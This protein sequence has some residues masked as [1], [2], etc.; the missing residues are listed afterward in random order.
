MSKK[1]LFSPCVPGCNGHMQFFMASCAALALW[2]SSQDYSLGRVVDP[3]WLAVAFGGLPLLFAA[4]THIAKHGEL[5]TKALSSLVV[6]ALCVLQTPFI[7]GQVA[8]IMLFGSAL[9]ICIACFAGR[10]LFN[11]FARQ[12]KAAKQMVHGSIWQSEATNLLP[13][14]IVQIEPQDI[15]PVDGLVMDGEAV[16]DAAHTGADQNSC[17]ARKGSTVRSGSIC[18]SGSFIMEAVHSAS[19][20]TIQGILG[21]IQQTEH[22]KARVERLANRWGGYLMPI[23]LLAALM[24]W[25]LSGH[26]SRGLS[27][28]LVFC[29]C[30]LVL[31]TPAAIVAALGNAARH[32]VL[33]RSGDVLERL[34]AIDQLAL[35][36]TG[37]L[38]LGSPE[39]QSIRCVSE[40]FDE[41]TCLSMA[42]SAESLSDR[43]FARALVAHAA[44]KH[45]ALSTP[46]VVE[47]KAGYGVKAEVDGKTIYLGSSAF[48]AAA[49]FGIPRG[50]MAEKAAH[51]VNGRSLLWLVIEEQLAAYIIF[52]DP[53]RPE[54]RDSLAACAALPLGLTVLS[55]D[56]S[57]TVRSIAE[58]AGI[59]SF[60]AELRPEDKV[61]AI[62]D[63]Q[64][65]G[66]NVCMVGCDLNDDPALK[67]AQVGLVMGGIGSNLPA[68]AADVAVLHSNLAA[69]PFVFRLAQKTMRNIESSIYISMALNSVALGC[70]AYGLLSLPQSALVHVLLSAAFSV[71]ALG[72]L[73]EKP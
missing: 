14:D 68:E 64:L 20:S 42:A 63:M 27:V 47:V 49:G 39:V 46:S 36:K 43:P 10:P 5:N 60:G 57:A 28:L 59:Q 31:A 66:H 72:L 18:L 3:A 50:I 35:D 1:T 38:T 30:V 53:V 54:A 26:I 48:I 22:T 62:L 71:R 15:L 65:Q 9:D 58:Q 69:L 33:I 40:H 61:K 56:Q 73:R 32:G 17:A 8:C 19:E 52:A 7:A 51:T 24:V 4:G 16:L 70:A 34:A 41:E 12:P 55:G 67:T 21:F 45:I 23:A 13:G 44:Q 11:F 2:A 25:A 29:P 37:I 6:I